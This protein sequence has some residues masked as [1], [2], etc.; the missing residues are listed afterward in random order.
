MLYHI[1]QDVAE[2]EGQKQKALFQAML[3]ARDR[4][5]LARRLTRAE[6]DRALLEYY[7]IVCYTILYYTRLRYYSI[8]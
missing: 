5:E 4:Q 7:T 1:I 6:E 8:L 2:V 3:H